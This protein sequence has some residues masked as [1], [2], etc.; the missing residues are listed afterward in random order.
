MLRAT[1]EN[2]CY[3]PHYYNTMSQFEM[4]VEP[5]QKPDF[6]VGDRVIATVASDDLDKGSNCNA[7]KFEETNLEIIG[8]K[9]RGAAT[10]A[11]TVGAQDDDECQH[12]P[13]YH[14][15]LPCAHMGPIR[16]QQIF[17]NAASGGLSRV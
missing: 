14:G 15:R 2:V 3:R 9:T 5:S 4:F 1:G 6:R 12:V 8:I 10:G 13:R 16:K 7:Q 17:D 11:I